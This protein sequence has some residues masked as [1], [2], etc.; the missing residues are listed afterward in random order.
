M[1]KEILYGA[2]ALMYV[3]C[4]VLGFVA[5]PT[6]AQSIAMTLLSFVFFLPPMWLLVDA[7]RQRDKKTLKALRI[8]S[9]SSLIL[10]TVAYIANLLSFTASETVGNALYYVLLAVSAPMVSMGVE[11]LSLFLW[12]CLLFGS[13]SLRNQK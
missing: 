7:I 10:T 9:L 5:E 3:L 11:L 12:A 13:F 1:K 6:D 2:W 8:V 4:A